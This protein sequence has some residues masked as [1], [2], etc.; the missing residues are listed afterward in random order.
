MDVPNNASLRLQSDQARHTEQL[1]SK[2]R[3]MESNEDNQGKTDKQS[4]MQL[5][6]LLDLAL[7]FLSTCSTETLLLVLACLM[8]ATYILLGRLGLI[9]IGVTLGVTLHAS[10]EGPSNYTSLES[11]IVGRR[12]LSMNIVHRVLD[13]QNNKPI[14]DFQGHGSSREIL[15]E[16]ES[17]MELDLSL[18]GPATATALQSLIDAAVRDYVNYWYKPILPSESTFPISCRRTITGFITSISSHLHRKRTTDTFL[19]FLTNSS[20]MVIVFLNELST[21]FEASGPVVP[22]ED[23]IL[24]YLESTPESSLSSLLANQH[25]QKKLTMISDDILSRFLGS[26]AYKCTP[27]RNF[28]REILAGVVLEST[29]SSMSRP[30]FINGWI[31]YLFSEGES[32]IMNAIDAGV[33]GARTHGVTAAKVSGEL[34]RPASIS[35]DCSVRESRSP[36]KDPGPAPNKTDQATEEA[37]VEAKRLSEMIAAQS[38]QEGSEQTTYNGVHERENSVDGNN[39]ITDANME[40]VAIKKPNHERPSLEGGSTER[41]RDALEVNPRELGSSRS[42]LSSH[43]P[44]ARSTNLPRENLDTSAS[45]ILHYAS[46]TVDDSLDTGDQAALRSKPTSSY[47]VQI[48]PHLGRSSGWMVF[49]KYA[50]F[51]S[52]H[53]TLGTISRLNQLRFGD[54]YPVVPP[55]KARTRKALARDLKRYL[56]DALQLEPLAESV[57]MRRFLEK[58]GCLG[59]EAAD[60]L[61]KP[62]F[63]FTGQT[64]FENVGKGVLGVL[65]NAP[66]GVSGGGKAVFEGVTGVFGGGANKRALTTP[67][68][69]NDINKHKGGL[70]KNELPLKTDDVK[71]DGSSRLSSDT[72]DS[73]LLSQLPES[74]NT[75]G[76][77]SPSPSEVASFAES[78]TPAQTPESW[79]NVID[80]TI[81]R[82]SSESASGNKS[83]MTPCSDNNSE[84]RDGSDAALRESRKSMGSSSRQKA[85]SGR[86]TADETR[87]AVEL[88]FAV[89]NELYSLSSAWNIRRTLLNAAKSYILRPGSP[90]IETIRDL[91]QESMIDSHT[92]DE[93]IAIHLTKLRENALPTAE[94]LSAWPSPMSDAEKK[95]QREAAR[96]ALV[97]KGL[98]QALTSVMGA[99]A[100]REA[101]G[102]VFDSLQVEV[103]ARGFVFSILL[104]GLRAVAL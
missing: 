13:W 17:D 50:D 25:Q 60:S 63:L 56:Q 14:E 40:G 12:L 104:Q 57:T 43:S 68:A 52:I 53:E 18:F 16:G 55:W 84:E 41:V 29:I 91:L 24:L 46:I 42:S 1:S 10:W 19:E 97:Q 44:E 59:A 93:A 78:S 89:I 31:E 6:E 62:G 76:L 47:L 86:I 73:A 80:D 66:K 38:L 23:A 92:S 32:E 70:Q 33:E 4:A 45:F 49:K 15:I 20:S 8:G 39:A 83:M 103:V 102:K 88:I 7:Q 37:M 74:S 95:R 67:G 69:K 99:V 28:L 82:A 2:E 3:T 36:L 9:I 81:G 75:P 101:L 22:A 27:V 34:T 90:S 71:K 87:M 96:R 21:A 30:E 61:T 35:A 26:D 100:S 11:R 79:E 94:E 5:K 64:A 85:Q 65:A 77:T 98:P 54:S 72:K 58:D 51:E 48:E